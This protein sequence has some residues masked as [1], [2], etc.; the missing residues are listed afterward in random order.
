MMDWI[1]LQRRVEE[2]WQ[3]HTARLKACLDLLE[4]I[5]SRPAGQPSHITYSY[6]QRVLGSSF[7]LQELNRILLYLASPSIG[8]LKMNFQLIDD[9]GHFELSDEDMWYASSTGQ[10]IHPETGEKIIGY[11]NKVHP[12]FSPTSSVCDLQ[13]ENAGKQS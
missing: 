1:S 9:Y 11:E 4:F 10:L 3:F 13:N 12:Y 8:V 5:K 2:D 6:T 7:D